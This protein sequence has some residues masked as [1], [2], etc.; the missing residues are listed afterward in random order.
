MLNRNL[1][2]YIMVAERGS[3]TETANELYVSQPAISKA[4]LKLEEEL[5]VTLFYRDKR[6][7]LL[8]T[9]VGKEILL[10]ARKMQDSANRIHQIARQEN[11]LLG[12]KLRVASFPIF[13]GAVLPAVIREFR[14]QYPAVSF[15]LLDRDPRTAQRLA[16]EHAADL[17]ISASPFTDL[18]HELLLEDQMIAIFPKDDPL[19]ESVSLFGDTQH[20]V[21]CE[22]G[23]ETVTDILKDASRIRFSESLIVQ[24]HE[25]II[26]MVERGNGVG[27]IDEFTFRAIRSDLQVCPV[28]PR[29]QI[30]IEL[31]APDLQNL[32]PAAAAF[33]DLLRAYISRQAP[34]GFYAYE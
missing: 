22:A 34:R 27:I 12:G 29:I 9:E 33:A 2:I 18:D 11:N 4:I 5:H 17:A 3:I 28:R 26:S 10:H 24:N 8:L 15:E 31:A 1:E 6:R 16:A 32:T 14:R 25:T 21:F 20:L 23:R 30:S 13:T 19:P 7:G